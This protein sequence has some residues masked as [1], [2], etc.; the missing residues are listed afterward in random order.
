MSGGSL[1]RAGRTLIGAVLTPSGAP[2]ARRRKRLAGGTVTV[3]LGLLVAG[4]AAAFA[5]SQASDVPTKD[6]AAIEAVVRDYILEH[7]EIV[8]EAMVKLEKNRVAALV[9]E[10]R[11]ALETPFA[12]AWEGA[13]KPQ[14]TLV[15]FMDYACGYCRAT[16]PTIAR[17]LKE[18]PGLRVVY[19]ELPIISQESVPAARVSLY[20]AETGHFPA[21]HQAMYSGE[22]VDKAAVID[23]AKKAGL[24][25]NKVK[26]EF[27]NAGRNP[28]IS[29]S[30]RLAQSLEAEGTPLLVVGDQIFYGAVSYDTLKAAIDAARKRG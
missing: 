20:A 7:P 14:V 24:D 6:R 16:V 5:A 29:Q 21:F 9:D 8:R 4:G 19:H 2:W 15:A 18:D 1:L 17:L 12:G 25:L 3:L 28:V 23:A 10:N 13:A 27:D 11:A 30:I 22:G 26:T